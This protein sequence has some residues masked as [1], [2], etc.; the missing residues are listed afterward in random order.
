[1][2]NVNHALLYGRVSG[3]PEWTHDGF[4]MVKI[5]RDRLDGKSGLSEVLFPCITDEDRF[6]KSLEKSVSG[7]EIM[8]RGQMRA[9]DIVTQEGMKKVQGLFIRD[10]ELGS[11]EMAIDLTP[12]QTNGLNSVEIRGQ[13]SP[14]GLQSG[15]YPN[16]TDYVRFQVRDSVNG[17][18]NCF[19]VGKS[20]ALLKEKAHPGSLLT[21]TGYMKTEKLYYG[22][23]AAFNSVL[24]SAERVN[25]AEIDKG[26][27][28]RKS[29]ER[30][31][32]QWDR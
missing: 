2:L 13:L 32:S 14:F 29:H 12:T 11:A 21:I 6:V 19:A 31:E 3:K 7:Q 10:L 1:M 27:I 16:G 17:L 24:V 15:K 25:I 28:S 9:F 5:A 26:S 20:A 18:V 8:V 22:D 30:N 4:L 23:N